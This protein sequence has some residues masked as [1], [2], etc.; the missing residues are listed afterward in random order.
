MIPSAPRRSRFGLVV[1]Q[2]WNALLGIVAEVLFAVTVL[3]LG[4]AVCV[5]WWR[6]FA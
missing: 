5:G 4:Y 1:R 2:V 3:A 6:L